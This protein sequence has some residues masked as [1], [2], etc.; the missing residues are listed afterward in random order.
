MIYAVACLMLGL[1]ITHFFSSLTVSLSKRN[2]KRGGN[3][4]G[5]GSAFVVVFMYIVG[6]FLLGFGAAMVLFLL[7]K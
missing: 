6:H 5:I 2:I 3:G 7:F 4:A 1:I